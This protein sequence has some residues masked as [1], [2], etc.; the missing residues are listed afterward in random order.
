MRRVVWSF[1]IG[2]LLVGCGSSSNSTPSSVS[3]S[4]TVATTDVPGS[5]P[6][7]R[8]EFAATLGEPV[9][10][11]SE[12]V[13]LAVHDDRTYIV[14]RGGL[15]SIFV[16]G[17]ADERALDM[18]DLTVPGGER[19]LLGLAFGDRHAFVN[20]TDLDGNTVVDRFVVRAD[21]TFDET[22][23]TTLLTVAQPYA[24]HNG[25]D[26]VY[27][28]DTASLLVFTGD[29]GAGGDPERHALDT[30]SPLGKVLRLR[31]VD[32][33]LVAVPVIPEV[34]AVGLRNPW[35]AHLDAVTGMLY[36]A[37]VGQDRW[38]EVN[39]VSLATLDGSSF[40]WSA[41]E[42]SHDFNADQAE[43]NSAFRYVA[44]RHEYEHVDGRCSISGGAAYRGSSIAHSG[45]WYVYADYCSGEVVAVDVLDQPGDA[46]EVLGTVPQPVAVV[47][48]ADGEL[49]V[50]SL[51]GLVVPIVPA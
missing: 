39:V 25:G 13:D 4:P 38:E 36:I 23:R 32:D 47:A 48:D 37:D 26:L 49:W 12:P 20:Y 43:A 15:V 2:L 34:A 33:E 31:G 29:G 1:A 30:G 40:G 44:P 41:L 50:L 17:V 14:E 11:A 5:T 46:V 21:G 10:G 9:E 22:T 6:V 3:S 27:D 35:R 51:T 45:N 24:N 28:P 8:V 16:D 7:D 42:G 18:S 19:G